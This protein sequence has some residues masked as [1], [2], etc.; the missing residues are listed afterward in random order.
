M[1]QIGKLIRVMGLGAMQKG[2]L[3]CFAIKSSILDVAV[4]VYQA[5]KWA[6]VFT[7]VSYNIYYWHVW[8]TH[9]RR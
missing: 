3:G 4:D 9:C 5:C 6:R 1:G 8:G 7:S 2:I